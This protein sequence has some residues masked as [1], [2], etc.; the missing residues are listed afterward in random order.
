MRSGWY[1]DDE[2]DASARPQH[3]GA[4][5]RGVAP[6]AVAE[7]GRSLLAGLAA[8]HA[9]AKITLAAIDERCPL[10]PATG[11]RIARVCMT[12]PSS[13]LGC[14][15]VRRIRRDLAP[16]WQPFRHQMLVVG[17]R[18][19]AGVSEPG[20]RTGRSGSYTCGFGRSLAPD[21]S[22][23]HECPDYWTRDLRVCSRRLEILLERASYG[24]LNRTHEVR[25]SIPL[26]STV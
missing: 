10:T 20:T 11:D 22:R 17:Q 2:H 13:R 3:R 16:P 26:S 8:P 21:F 24:H 25:G 6:R 1:G 9:T 23:A 14:E 15:T 5:R 4:S 12:V 19:A 18:R 7:L